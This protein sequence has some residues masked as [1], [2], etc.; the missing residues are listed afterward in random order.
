[1]DE[2]KK[3][4]KT[5]KHMLALYAMLF[6][7]LAIMTINQFAIADVN[8][9]MS[10]VPAAKKI[11]IQAIQLSANSQIDVMPSGIPEIY[12][13]ELGVRYDDVSASDQVKTE[14]TIQKLGN[15]DRTIT[16]SGNNLARYITTA[17]QISCEYCCGVES[18]IF[19]NGNPACGCAHSY[20]M[21]GVAKYLLTNHPEMTNDQ[22]L[23]ELGKWKTLFFPGV[24]SQK[25]AIL[26]QKGIELNYINLASNKYRGIE[27]EASSSSTGNMVGGC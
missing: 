8:S 25:A 20:A 5:G 21:R 22:I 4:Y 13:Q 19:S 15:L 26:Q 18:I 14:A 16:L 10:A 9:K 2:D 24:I 27:S 11:T 17:S 23:E 1:M 3:H 12:G 6:V 7:T